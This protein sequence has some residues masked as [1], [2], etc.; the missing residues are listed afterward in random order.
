ESSGQSVGNFDCIRRD[1]ISASKFIDI[2]NR[3]GTADNPGIIA[4]VGQREVLIAGSISQFTVVDSQNQAGTSGSRDDIRLCFVETVIGIEGCT[5]EIGDNFL[6]ILENLVFSVRD[7][8]SPEEGEQEH[9]YQDN[10]PDHCQTVAE[11]PL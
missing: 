7:N 11:K 10:K 8:C 4:Q 9:T 3:S 2:S 6:I 1:H 5:G